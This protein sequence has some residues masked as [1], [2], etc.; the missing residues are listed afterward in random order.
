MAVYSNTFG[1]L[2]LTGD[3][4]KKFRNQVRYGRPNQAAKDAVRRGMAMAEQLRAN[5]YIKVDSEVD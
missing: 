3:E 1:G 5:G 4:A 2:V